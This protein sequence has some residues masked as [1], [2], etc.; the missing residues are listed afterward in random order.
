MI[1]FHHGCTV[2][3]AT[4]AYTKEEKFVI[5]T[6]VSSFQLRHMT[7][8]IKRIDTNAFVVNLDVNHIHGEFYMPPI[9]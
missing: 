9:N 3:P 7:N 8:A 5:H 2:F 6:V 4:G 1:N